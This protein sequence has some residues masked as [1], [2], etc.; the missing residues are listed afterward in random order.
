MHALGSP[1][2]LV[3][4][5]LASQI[6][7]FRF[8]SHRAHKRVGFSVVAQ[9]LATLVNPATGRIRDWGFRFHAFTTPE[10]TE[11]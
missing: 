1:D 5:D 3:V 6:L 7:S 2:H 10:A 9:G 8:A 11:Y 4:R